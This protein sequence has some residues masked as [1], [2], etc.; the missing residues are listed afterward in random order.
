MTSDS[1]SQTIKPSFNVYWGK[2]GTPQKVSIEFQMKGATLTVPD[3]TFET[4]QEFITYLQDELN[5][6]RERF[7]AYMENY[8]KSDM[9]FEDDSILKTVEEHIYDT[10]N[11][12]K[13]E[14]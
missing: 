13:E 5:G 2:I 1:S 3:L 7:Y 11:K 6:T 14:K 9:V 12:V 4:A 8:G 10:S